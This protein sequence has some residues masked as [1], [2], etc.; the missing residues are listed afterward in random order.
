MSKK[1]TTEEFILRA[2]GVHGDKYD[3]SK[4]N[5]I[6]AKTKIIIICPIHGEFEQTPTTHIN[7]KYGCYKCGDILK[8]KNQLSN[9]NEFINKAILIHGNTYDYSLTNYNGAKNKVEIICKEHDIFN[10]TPDNHIHRHGGCPICKNKK[11]RDK[12]ISNTKEF[13]KKSSQKHNNF[14]DYSLANYNG[15]KN[16][17]KIICPKHGE[18]IQRATNHLKGDGC[19]ICKQ[20]KGE[21]EIRKILIDKEI[22]YHP[23]YKF[24]DCKFI[25][26]LPF[27]FYLPDLNTCIEYHGRQHYE[28]I[29]FFGG[30]LGFE[31][32]KMRDKIKKDYCKKHNIKLIVIPY[33]KDVNDELLRIL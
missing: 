29:N 2:K 3:Y 13:I 4:A 16:K 9:K 28:S 27:D 14:Y 26:K 32:T 8:R 12:Q 25:N 24:D 15:A 1:L 17:I 6:K 18:F 20:S 21:L 11:I 19:P 33:Y 7:K 30:N 23:Q 22:V 31:N 10:T 5:Y